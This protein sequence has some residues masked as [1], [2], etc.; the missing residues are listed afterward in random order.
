MQREYPVEVRWAP[1]L[2]DPSIP[3]EGRSRQPMTKPGD[4]PSHLETR[5]E[6][7]GLLFAR[8]RTFTPNSHLSLELGHWAQ[9]QGHDGDLHRKLF[10]EHFSDLGNL[11][12]IDTL[13]RV[14]ADAGLNG[15]EARDVLETRRYREAVD[16]GIEWAYAIG[17]TAVPTFI[18][19]DRYAIVGAEEY[20]AFQRMMERL[21][22]PVPPGVEPPPDDMR[23]TFPGEAGAAPTGED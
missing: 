18:F 1:F 2:L 23:L 7:S 19:N 9:E 16:Q 13:V 11:G 22:H 21:G 20:P 6:R 4:P 3:P 17:V 12:D 8:G 14:A 10:K 5:G 15:D